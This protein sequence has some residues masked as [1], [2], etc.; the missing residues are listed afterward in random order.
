VALLVLVRR[1]WLALLAL[2]AGCTSTPN[3]VASEPAYLRP[4][5]TT[6][7]IASPGGSFRIHFTRTGADAVP[8]ADVDGNGTPDFVDYIAAQYDM[9][10]ARYTAMGF[11]APLSDAMVTPDNGGDGKFDVYL[12]SFAG[13]GGEADGQFTREQCSASGC[14]GYML[15]ANT[16]STGVY[17]SWQY[18]ARLVAAHELFHAVQAAY[19]DSLSAQGSTLAESTAVWASYQYDNSLSDLMDFGAAFLMRPDRALEIDPIGPVQPYAYGA[20]VVWEYY[21]TRF[22]PT[23]VVHFWDT[24]AITTTATASNWLDVLDT[25]LMT[26]H[27]IGFRATYADLA[28]WLMFTGARYDAM[29]GPQRGQLYT[30]V[31][32]TSVALPYTTLST[33]IFPASSHY[34]LVS[35]DH[36]SVRLTNGDPSGIDVIAVGFAGNAFVRDARGVGQLDLM[37]AGADSILIALANGARSGMS[38]AVSICIA[39]IASDCSTTGTDAGVVGDASVPA[40]ATI[41]PAPAPSCGCRA[42]GGRASLVA[43]G[44]L[45]AACLQR[46]RSPRR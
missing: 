27:A 36:V 45:A 43:L 19:A 14:I 13:M 26:D 9:V 25:V 18:G 5:T 20:A 31:A 21:S 46:R 34:F 8:P 24:L 10:L 1:R 42:G 32:A 30:E 39:G 23:L 41:A 4:A 44:L 7:S 37:A 29:R 6:E 2:L 40:D 12:V 3:V 38:D 11:R 16:F 15:E 28:E 17:P 35:G 33:R 22:D